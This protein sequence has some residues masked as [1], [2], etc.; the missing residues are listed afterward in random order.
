MDKK[1]VLSVLDAIRGRFPKT[2]EFI[3]ST[4]KKECEKKGECRGGNFLQ[5]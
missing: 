1:I 5:V 2:Q 4:L 3:G